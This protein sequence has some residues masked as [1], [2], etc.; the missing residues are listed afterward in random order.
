MGVTMPQLDQ[1]SAC[2]GCGEPLEDDDRFCGVCGTDLR[3][4]ARPAA[5]RRS[6]PQTPQK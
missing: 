3:T 5:V 4:A 6:V 2:P 1:L